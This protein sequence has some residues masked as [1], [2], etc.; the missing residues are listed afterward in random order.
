[1][2]N[3]TVINNTCMDLSDFFFQAKKW[4]IIW[5][6]LIWFSENG[7]SERGHDLQTLTFEAQKPVCLPS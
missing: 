6:S 7:L 4:L 5:I 3:A 1:M 2:L